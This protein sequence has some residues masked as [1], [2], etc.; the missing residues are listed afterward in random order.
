MARRSCAISPDTL[1]SLE[2][3][4][5]TVHTLGG[6]Q[7]ADLSGTSPELRS[8]VASARKATDEFV[9]WLEKL[10]PTKTGPSGVGKENYTWYQQNV[11]FIPSTGMKKSSC[12]AAN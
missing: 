7:H 10:A 9:A 5:L 11:H 1:A 12:C 8:A 3:G 4:T 2:A 6:A